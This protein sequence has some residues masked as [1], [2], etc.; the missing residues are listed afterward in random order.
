MSKPCHFA[1]IEYKSTFYIAV[2]SVLHAE[3]LCFNNDLFL[4][5][6][7]D[8]LLLNHL[9]FAPLVQ[10]SKLMIIKTCCLAL[11]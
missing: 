7:V 2:K 6:L 5:L 10:P 4:T 9:V 8:V 1:K 3:F 11:L